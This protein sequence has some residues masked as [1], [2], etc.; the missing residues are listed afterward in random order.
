MGA[1]I[2]YFSRARHKGNVFAMYLTLYGVGRFFIEGLRTDSL[3]MIPGVIRVSQ[4]LSAILVVFGVAYLL[5]MHKKPVKLREYQGIYSLGYKKPEKGQNISAEEAVNDSEE[6]SNS[7]KRRKK[8]KTNTRTRKTSMRNLTMMTDLYQLTMMYGYFREKTHENMA[9]YDV[10]FRKGAGN[11]NMPYSPGWSRSS[12]ILITCTL[13]R[14]ISPICA[15]SICS[16]RISSSTCGTSAL[17]EKS[18]P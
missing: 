3:W 4:L 9:V 17:P 8:K 11:P 12:S 10:F 18:T 13:L 14:K 15:R 16:M 7:L 2:W 6:V 5:F 1:L